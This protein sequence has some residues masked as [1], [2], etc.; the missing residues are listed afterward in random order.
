M[1]ACAALW[2]GAVVAHG[3][4]ASSPWLRYAASPA[5]QWL[6]AA[7]VREAP[8]R[9][10]LVGSSPV[11]FGL[12]AGTLSRSTGCSVV[13]AS[14]TNIGTQVD[15]YLA[16]TLKHVRPGDYVVLTDRRWT[17]LPLKPNTCADAPGWRCFLSS[18]RPVPYA[19]G[20][21]KAL[22]GSAYPRD[23]RGDLIRFPPPASRFAALPAAPLNDVEYRLQRMS[24]QVAMIRQRGAH[25]LLAAAPLLVEQAAQPAVQHE[26]LRFDQLVR[27]RIGPATWVPPLVETEVGLFVLDGQ[28]ASQ[29]GRIAW[30]AQVEAALMRLRNNSGA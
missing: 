14:H 9:V 8:C 23:E 2:L 5:R 13:N 11:V 3:V 27:S 26:F 28:H 4:I 1:W 22:T 16:L 19:M 30:T 25:A 21:Y 17:D 18:V 6:Q 20:D 24:R 15:Q 29:R 7:S 10:F 12:S